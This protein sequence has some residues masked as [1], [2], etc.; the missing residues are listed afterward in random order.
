MRA[1]YQVSLPYTVPPSSFPTRPAS[2]I[3]IGS[4]SEGSPTAEDHAPLWNGE[5]LTDQGASFA[6]HLA[7]TAG[8]LQVDEM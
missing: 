4:H 8:L 5:E 1:G 2:P 6:Q 3:L 7:M